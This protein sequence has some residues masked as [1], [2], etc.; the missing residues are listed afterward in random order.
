MQHMCTVHR[1]ILPMKLG[2]R[3]IWQRIK[4]DTVRCEFAWYTL[5]AI[6]T[7]FDFAYEC[8]HRRSP[9]L[10]YFIQSEIIEPNSAPHCN[11]TPHRD[12]AVS[13]YW[14]TLI[15]ISHQ[16]IGIAQCSYLPFVLSF[17]GIQ[18]SFQFV[19]VP[20]KCNFTA[21]SSS[22]SIEKSTQYTVL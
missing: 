3:G 21:C 18:F 14:R 16:S 4:Y 11:F 17:S 19:I 7:C 20:V 1:T 8:I 13:F 15:A 5:F 22:I 9:C 2:Y 10:R 12:T 6:V